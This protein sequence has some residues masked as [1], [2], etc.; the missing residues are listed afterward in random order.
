M[1]QKFFYL[2]VILLACACNDNS[3]EE[4]TDGY[5]KRPQNPED[6]L[7]EEVMHGHDTAMAKMG[8]LS[9]YQKQVKEK[10]DS[11]EKTGAKATASLKSALR[12]L[13]S[14]LEK[15]EDGMNKWM[16]DFD[17][18]SAQDNVERRLEYLKS[19]KI[20]VDDVKEKIF[21]TLKKADSLLKK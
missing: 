1:L 17:I 3:S 19:E 16:E 4:R 14:D 15:A 11:L 2:A 6:S 12:E 10:L 7:F 5:S 8:K 13:G 9:G 21:E 20:K 18:D